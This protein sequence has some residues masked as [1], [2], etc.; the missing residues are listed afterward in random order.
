MHSGLPTFSAFRI[1]DIALDNGSFKDIFAPSSVEFLETYISCDLSEAS[2]A[3]IQTIFAYVATSR[4]TPSALL[5]VY[6]TTPLFGSV[7]FYELVVFCRLRFKLV[8]HLFEI[9]CGHF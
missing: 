7:M 1:F 6:T 9:A 4:A 2:S 5:V 8:Q 3:E